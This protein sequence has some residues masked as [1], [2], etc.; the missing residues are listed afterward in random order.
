MKM[1]TISQK[2]NQPGL[3]FRRSSNDGKKKKLSSKL[4]SFGMKIIQR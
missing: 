4:S 1:H 3:I 2:E